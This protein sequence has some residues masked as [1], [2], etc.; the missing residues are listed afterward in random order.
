MLLALVTA[1]ALLARPAPT[2]T[3]A[4]GAALVGQWESAER[5]K[6]GVGNILEFYPDGRLTQI[7]ASMADAGYVID[8]D[9]LRTFWK[10][11][12][13]GRISEVETEI[14][15]EGNTRFLEKG[16][17]ATGESWSERVGAAPRSGSPL[18]GQWCSLFL[19]TLTTYREF[20]RDR[21]YN[22]L[23]VV[24]LRGRYSVTGDSLRVGDAGATRGRVPVPDRQRRAGH[25]E[26]Q[27]GGEALQAARDVA[28]QGVLKPGS[29]AVDGRRERV[30]CDRQFRFFCRTEVLMKRALGLSCLLLV[31]GLSHA[32]AQVSQRL[33]R[34]EVSFATHHDTSPPLRDMPLVEPMFVADHEKPRPIPVPNAEGLAADQADPAAQMSAN[35]LVAA[36]LGAGFDGLGVGGPYTPDAAPPDTN[37]AVGSTQYVQWVNEAFAVYNKSTG[38][39]VYG[40]TAGNTLWSGFGGGCQNNN[41]GDP[42]VQYDKAANRWIMTQFSVSTTPYTQCVAVSQTSDATG[43]WYRYSFSYGT[44]TF[45]DYPK[46]GVWPD[47]YYVTYN[48]F[49][50]SFRG[51]KVCAFDRAKMLTGAAATQQCFQLSTSY[52]GLLPSDVDGATAPPAGS[53]N[54]MVNFGHEPAEPLEVPRGLGDAGQ[55][56]AHRP[57]RHHDGGLHGGLQRRG[58]LPQAVRDDPASSIPS[59]TA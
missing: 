34:P 29:P 26:P 56:D 49:T 9:R 1:L 20:T 50:S 8:G 30:Y 36:T 4:P 52:G 57:D 44:S 7:S 11:P 10:D 41:D 2:P 59:P 37:G 42:I 3:P 21:M 27:R 31:F 48:M 46:L 18:I 47:G 15:F 5:T 22:R 6:E 38:A 53:P 58:R 25:Q 12:E 51:A 17:E 55:H 40:P 45:N 39:L 54:Y 23:P 19:E 43:A 13:T 14:S 32:S 35:V 28:A 16:D 33:T 24:V